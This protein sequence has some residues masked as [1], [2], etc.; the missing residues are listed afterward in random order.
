MEVWSSIHYPVG[1]ESRGELRAMFELQAT[2]L[3]HLLLASFIQLLFAPPPALV[4]Y[5]PLALALVAFL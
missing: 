3:F 2:A 1:N 4:S 5:R